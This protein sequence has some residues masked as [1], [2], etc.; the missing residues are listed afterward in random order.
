MLLCMISY[1]VMSCVL[2]VKYCNHLLA[3]DMAGVACRG[4][5]MHVV[6]KMSEDIGMGVRK[7]TV[8]SFVPTLFG[9]FLAMP[10]LYVFSFFFMFFFEFFFL[11]GG[12]GI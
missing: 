4:L 9:C 11:G 1:S 12:G 2:H 5:C 3:V 7:G 6:G 8:V 10:S